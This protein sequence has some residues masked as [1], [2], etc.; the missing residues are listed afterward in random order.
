VVATSRATGIPSRANSTQTGPRI[1]L[2]NP[3]SKLTGKTSTEN[4]LW[5]LTRYSITLSLSQSGTAKLNCITSRWRT[6]SLARRRKR[7][8]KSSFGRLEGL[9]VPDI[10][11]MSTV[12]MISGAWLG[13][14][15]NGGTMST[16]EVNVWVWLGMVALRKLEVLLPMQNW[17]WPHFIWSSQ[18]VPQISQ[19]PSVEIV[20]FCRSPQWYTK[21]VKFQNCSVHDF[22]LMPRF[23]GAIRIFGDGKVDF[24]TRP[25]DYAHVQKL[26]HAVCMWSLSKGC[27]LLVN[28]KFH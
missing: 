21:R 12:R 25:P 23:A 27:W 13:I 2:A 4:T 22:S 3:R 17:S 28:L 16:W 9:W 19:N 18:L 7:M 15:G 6:L 26:P 1:T 10:P 11:A 14:W 24:C 5:H 8:Q 20:N